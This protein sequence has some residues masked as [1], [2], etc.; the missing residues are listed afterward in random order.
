MDARGQP[1]A[2]LESVRLST[3]E[4]GARSALTVIRWPSTKPG[5]RLGPGRFSGPPTISHA[6]EQPEPR[7]ATA[8]AAS[9]LGIQKAALVAHIRRTY[10]SDEGRTVE[11]ADIVVPAAH[12]EIAY[13]IPINL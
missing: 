9:L 13:E 6:V 8:E 3:R 11:T 1:L 2:Q 7:H 10:Y 12:C 5:C 4:V